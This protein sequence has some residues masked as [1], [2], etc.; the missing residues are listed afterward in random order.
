VSED[1]PIGHTQIID[2]FDSSFCSIY[3][4]K[5]HTNH[6]HDIPFEIL[7]STNGS[8][9][10]TLHVIHPL[11]REQT[12]MYTIRRQLINENNL[13]DNDIIN[14][15]LS[16]VV[17]DVNDHVPQFESEHFLFLIPEN[18]P[19]GSLIGRVQAHDPDIF[20]NGKISYTLFGHD[21]IQT[22][23]K[24]MFRID[25]ETGE[26]FLLDYTLDYET[27]KEYTLMVEA[28]DH[29]DVEAT[30]WPS[31]PSYA[32]IILTIEDVN[33]QK[34]QIIFTM[35]NEHE[36]DD[37]IKF[38]NTSNPDLDNS[39]L[40][41]ISFSIKIISFRSNSSFKFLSFNNKSS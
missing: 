29:G 11:D 27:K 32:D 33:D 12:P 13:N 19:P 35:S 22:G 24:T 8:C 16:I 17:L 3:S 31:V 40:H 23:N 21:L 2:T 37:D 26:L 5:S 4:I 10:L 1:V 9:T 28:K 20:L 30:L 41:K 7:L 36:H 38:M 15:H 18:L 39:L 14:I 6:R 34:P 25:K